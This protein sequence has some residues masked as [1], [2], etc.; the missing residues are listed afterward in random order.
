MTQAYFLALDQDDLS[1]DAAEAMVA[2][3]DGRCSILDYE[4]SADEADTIGVYW[5]AAP[6]SSA[7][8]GP[9]EAVSVYPASG[10]RAREIF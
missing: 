8:G 1:R 10:G 9:A 4:E 2:Y 5:F 3:H 6:A 7:P